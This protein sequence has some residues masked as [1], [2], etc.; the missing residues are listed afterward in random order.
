M[1]FTR[2]HSVDHALKW[3]PAPRDLTLVSEHAGNRFGQQPCERERAEAEQTSS[4]H[5]AYSPCRDSSPRSPTLAF[6]GRMTRTG[7]RS[8]CC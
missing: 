5:G 4:A 7:E 2:R 6:R 8:C 3:T 1:A